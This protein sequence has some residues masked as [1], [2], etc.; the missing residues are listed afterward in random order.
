MIPP[1]AD[2]GRLH[3]KRILFTRP[4]EYAGELVPR[5]EELGA[6]VLWIPAIRVTAAPLDARA[7][8]AL[9]ELQRYRWIAFASANGVRFF[10]DLLKQ[11]GLNIR[12]HQKIAAVGPATASS[13]EAAGIAVDLVPEKSTGADLARR[14]LADAE[15]GTILL[16]C[17]QRARPELPGLLAEGGWDVERLICYETLPAEL[18]P[19]DLRRLRLG[20]DAALFA[21][22]SQVEGIWDALDAGERDVLRKAALIPIGTTTAGALQAH[23]L[24]PAAVPPDPSAEAWVATL[25]RT[26]EAEAP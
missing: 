21:S 7:E 10:L 2:S 12:P 15:P 4:R 18:S 23:G 13:L 20:V 3:G 26:F 19:E 25:L 1:P 14:L 5:L 6:E 8:T 22:P 9:T 11:R 24:H 16:P 17:G